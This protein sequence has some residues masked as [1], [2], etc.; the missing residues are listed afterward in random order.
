[1]KQPAQRQEDSATFHGAAL[2]ALLVVVALLAVGCGGTATVTGADIPAT[3]PE[4]VEPTNQV[5]PTV[6][7][8]EPT[9]PTA[10]PEPAATATPEPIPDPDPTNVPDV[11]GWSNGVEVGSCFNGSDG[12]PV[13]AITCD[14]DHENELFLLAELPD[15]PDAPFRSGADFVDE[16]F[17]TTCDGA[18]EDFAG[19][20]WDELPFRTAVI[21]PSADQWAAGDRTIGCVAQSGLEDQPTKIGTAAGGDLDSDDGIVAR[22]SVGGQS[23]FFFSFEASTLYPLTEGEFDLPADTPQVSPSGFQFGSREQGA[24][25]GAQ[26]WTY[27]FDSLE[28]A[29]LETGLP[30]SW[31]IAGVHFVVA[32]PAFMFAARE[33]ENDDWEIYIHETDNGSLALTDNTIDDQFPSLTADES[34]I[35]WS[36][37]GDIWRMDLQG[38]NKVQLTDGPGDAF[39]SQVSPDGSTIVFTSS[40]SGNE[41]VW[42]MNAD[43]SNPV[44]L[45]NHPAVDSWPFFSEDGSLIYFQTDRV[46]VN[47][48]IM[49]MEPD[50]S[51]QSYYSFE[52]MTNAA[53]LPDSLTERFK[54]ELRG[55]D[56]G[57]AEQGEPVEPDEPAEPEQPDDAGSGVTEDDVLIVPGPT[58]ELTEVAHSQGRI[59]TALPGDW[60]Y[61]ERATNG[62]LS[63]VA[64]PSLDDFDSRWDVLGVTYTVLDVEDAA[65]VRGLV[66][67]APASDDSSCVEDSDSTEVDGELTTTVRRYSCGR[68]GQAVVV[69]IFDADDGTALVFEGQWADDADGQASSDLI[70]EISDASRWG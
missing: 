1:M 3:D 29:Q 20:A 15:G 4:L 52:Y 56:E 10:V 33:D 14:E 69:G 5:E 60:E 50:G 48:I 61:R 9:A 23:D 40:G 24:R 49:M 44:N 38:N 34:Q 26:A 41:D 39:E 30:D 42:S 53:L 37:G 66:D 28:S 25:S 36:A 59:V 65:E 43:G 11:A 12:E 18:T 17:E 47:S 21:S 2:C 6:S 45:T 19:A 46:G 62:V 22:A 32:I 27:L 70:E 16:I 57:P 13:V 64:A 7:Q 68:Q 55:L 8:V 67:L 58:D 31:E 51:N 54:E 63:L 35:L